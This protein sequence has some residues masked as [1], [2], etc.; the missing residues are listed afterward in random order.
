MDVPVDL[1]VIFEQPPSHV[2][3]GLLVGSRFESHGAQL[4][5]DISD[6]LL[7]LASHFVDD[8]LALACQSCLE[9]GLEG[10]DNFV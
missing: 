9:L 3:V 1:G 4:M 10:C 6:Q 2:D 8:L 5:S 7:V